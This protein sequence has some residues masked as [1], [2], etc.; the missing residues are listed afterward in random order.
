[1]ATYINGV[2]DYIPQIQPFKPDFN[3]FQ[4]ALEKKQLQYQAG[5]NKISKVYGQLLNSSLTRQAN[6][7]RRDELFTQIDSEIHRLSGVDLSLQENVQAASTLFQPLIDSSYFRKD[8]AFTKQYEGELRR[9][10]ALR[11]KPDPKSDIKW[12]QEGDSALHYQAQDFAKSTDEESLGFSAPR[13]VPFVNT[14]DMLFK[15]AKDNSIDPKS[16]S[17]DGGF[18]FTYKNGS[19]AIPVLNSVFSS[20]L[21]NDPRVKDMAN[22]Q[23]YLNR[24]NYIAE[25]VQ[26]FNGDEY[27]AETEY[28]KTKVNDIN[29]Y[30]RKLAEDGKQKS[31]K[32]KSTKS[33]IEDKIQKN[34]VDPDIDKDLI[35]IYQNLKNDDQVQSSVNDQ[36]NEALTNTDAIN[37]DDGDRETLRYRVDN[38]M[39]GLLIQQMAGETATQYAL[40]KADVEVKENP[41]AMAAMNHRYRMIEN[42]QKF[43][44]DKALKVM[45]IAT[46]SLKNKGEA[47]QGES[48]NPTFYKGTVIEKPGT[49]N[50][51]IT[52]VHVQEQN[53]RKVASFANDGMTL[54]MANA[55]AFLNQQNYIIET[56]SPDQKALAEQNIKS[57]LGEYSSQKSPEISL[58]H[59]ND[60]IKWGQLGTSLLEMVGGTVM[61]ALSGVGELASLGLATP[62]AA[63]GAIGGAGFAAHGASQFGDAL[64][65]S[66]EQI[67]V[68][69]AT[70]SSKGL[71]IRQTNGTYK[72]ANQKDIPALSDPN[73]GDYY[74]EVNKRI[75]GYSDQY[76]KMDPTDPAAAVLK[77]QIDQYT[78]EINAN[79]KLISAASSIIAE[80]NSKLTTALAAQSGANMSD[81]NNF[82]TPD[83]TRTLTENEFVVKYVDWMSR[84]EQ[85]AQYDNPSQDDIIDYAQGLY[86]D[87]TDS[88]EDLKKDPDA[89]IGIKSLD[90]YLPG[91]G[92]INRFFGKAAK[93]D[94]D[95][96][97]YSAPSYQMAMDFFQKDFTPNTLSRDALNQS[98]AKVIMGSGFDI[99]D[100]N[101]NDATTQESLK[102]ANILK[103]FL[104]SAMINQGGKTGE[105]IQRPA[106][107]YYL[108]AVAANNS[109][110]VAMTW[111]LSPEWVKDHAGTN[112]SHGITWELYKNMVNGGVDK[113][114][115]SNSQITF[116]MDADKV[117]SDPFKHMQ[118]NKP[119]AL[120]AMTGS[121]NIDYSGTGNINVT[122]GV[123]GGYTYRGTVKSIDGSG[124]PVDNS[125]Y[126]TTDVDFNALNQKLN[127]VLQQ[128]A[129]A[130]LQMQNTLRTASP[131]TIKDPL[132]LQ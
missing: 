34:G 73:S 69:S 10:N 23:S 82:F 26:K 91:E 75:K 77:N 57:V 92:G 80:N 25:N 68:A 41:V 55:E 105:N 22:V 53:E 56:G 71:A 28:L 32:I 121:Y 123:N 101:Y 60:D 72:L 24:K 84:P 95:S 98:G 18:I 117:E 8:L 2:T 122:P 70:T 104:S 51:D 43:E 112:T 74:S 81:V 5:Y 119:E 47:S 52:D 115:K 20:V 66:D 27:A 90:P 15:F 16:I 131:N 49:G 9:S 59:H 78:N 19:Q 129:K 30:F 103:A 113:D 4:S 93:Y 126:G 130:N 100:E 99:T 42:Q 48:L 89:E 67:K 125:I 58:E 50:V 39:S 102:N 1:M 96:A 46:Q 79:D 132:Q 116:I 40:A 86:E 63:A 118:M 33:V 44:F 12:W 106:G 21:A 108:H 110:K 62:L 61:V 11:K 45:D 111:D 128:A 37:F 114:G 120:M 85:Q 29:T 109:D 6:V 14:T 35:E 124:K 65:G 7:D 87:I 13:Y 88:Y 36:A 83:K 76:I 54:T 64:Y 107:S 3:F 97:V 31:D 17:F 38:A 127:E 94:F